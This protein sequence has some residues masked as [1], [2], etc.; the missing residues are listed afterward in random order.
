MGSKIQSA[1]RNR[2]GWSDTMKQLFKI[3][4]EKGVRQNWHEKEWQRLDDSLLNI[5]TERRIRGDEWNQIERLLQSRSQP[6]T[7]SDRSEWSATLM[8]AVDRSMPQAYRRA[9]PM[10]AWA[11]EPWLNRRCASVEVGLRLSEFEATAPTL[12][13]RVLQD[14]CVS[15]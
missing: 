10:D 9:A 7:R 11:A 15:L 13:Q 6:R 3:T 2:K 14:G 8:H 4:I 5:R 12:G 1:W